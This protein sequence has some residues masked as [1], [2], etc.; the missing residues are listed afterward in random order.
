MIGTILNN[1]YEILEKI[2]EGGMAEVYKARCH[3][4]NRYDA[5]KILKR[6]SAND[7]IVVEKFKRE[8]TA[9]ANLSDS[10]I[11]NIFD[12]GTQDG[13]NYIV[14]EYVKEKH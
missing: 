13:V 4:L 5:V 8:A 10:N 2:G 1:R 9:V 7:P 3:K 11:V 6:D 14:M 12:V